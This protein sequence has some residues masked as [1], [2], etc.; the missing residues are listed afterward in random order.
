MEV[1]CLKVCMLTSGH[2]FMDNRIFLKE[3]H[4]LHESGYDVSFVVPLDT[5]GFFMDPLNK[6]LNNIYPKTIFEQDGI[7]VYGYHK[8]RRDSSG[9]HPDE[10]RYKVHMDFIDNIKNNTIDDLEED[11]I[12]KGMEIDANIYH[13]HEISSAYAAVKIKQLKAK[14]GKE[15]KVVYDV[16]EYFPSIY[17]DVV[18]TL[19][20][21]RE[22]YRRM[23]QDFDRTALPYCDLVITVSEAI[24]GYFLQL[25]S[26]SNV[27]VI[28]NVPLLHPKSNTDK[29]ENE[30]PIVC[31]EGFIR[32]ER[33]LKEII[34]V[35]KLLKDTYPSFKL[36]MVGDAIGKEKELLHQYIEKYGLHE[37]IL[38][39]GW[40]APDEAAA[41]LEECDVGLQMLTDFPYWHL[42]MSNKLF[43]Y[44]RAG[45]A[46]VSIDYP[47]MGRV[48]REID[49][50]ICVRDMDP[51][52]WAQQ[53]G[54][55]LNDPVKLRALKNNARRGYKDKYNWGL[56]GKK[57][58][59]LYS[60]L[61]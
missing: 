53:I 32:F 44:M 25:D 5:Q 11:L 3:A 15:V 54:L 2:S 17:G 20:E 50:G 43:N 36:I 48:I 45:L 56:E 57:L 19:D 60:S 58:V 6:P 30:F 42:T 49:A 29:N 61:N 24:R 23:I 21:Y 7:C 22:T 16:H 39:T 41:I 13:A 18:A 47:E 35:A 12:K 33:G 55:L 28:K 46:I 34:E 4:T 51:K 37:T 26:K 9:E 40:K 31:Y 59:K 8:T 38:I 14:E 1:F 27:D 52:S 10:V